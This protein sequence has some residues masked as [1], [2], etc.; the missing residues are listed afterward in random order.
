MC[1]SN[2]R[3]GSYLDFASYYPRTS[4]VMSNEQYKNYNEVKPN[5]Q[6]NLSTM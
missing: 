4:N 5:V 6:L 3:Y 1:E 2:R